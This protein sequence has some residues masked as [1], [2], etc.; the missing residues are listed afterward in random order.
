MS[1]I[2]TTAS[3]PETTG[4]AAATGAAEP[5]WAAGRERATHR[6][7][8]QYIRTS[9]ATTNDVAERRPAPYPGERTIAAGYGSTEFTDSRVGA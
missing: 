4:T 6:G 1:T 7:L 2:D 5:A 8:R 3:H 9:V